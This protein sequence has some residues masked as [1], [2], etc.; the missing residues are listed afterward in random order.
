LWRN[1]LEAFQSVAQSEGVG[2]NS[3]KPNT[4]EKWRFDST[5]SNSAVLITLNNPLSIDTICIGSHN[6]G[7]INADVSI[8][9]STDGVTFVDWEPD[10]AVTSNAPIMRHI[11]TARSVKALQISIPSGATG[12]G[13]IGFIS[14]GEA[15]QMQRPFFNGHTPI[16]DGDATQYYSNR[17]ESGE[18]IG[19]QIRR[20]G[21]ETSADW[22]NIDDTWYR[23]YFAPFKQSAKLRPFFFAWNL[24]E[25]PD[26]VGFCRISQDISAP[27]QN[28]TVTKRSISMNL[29]GA[30]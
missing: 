15:L 25:Y 3:I 7:D 10:F 27:M 2:I 5:A 24:L 6:L 19:Q 21:F 9:Y 20:Q 12:L 16:T 18:I 4:W 14:A 11:A 30:G 23:T 8:T 1:K 13:E 22:Q 29:L 28:G 17:T 26:D